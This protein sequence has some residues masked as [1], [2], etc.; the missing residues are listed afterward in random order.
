VFGMNVAGMPGLEN[1][2]AFRILSAA[3]ALL[4]ALLIGYIWWKKWF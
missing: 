4:V 2:D 3:M 1:P